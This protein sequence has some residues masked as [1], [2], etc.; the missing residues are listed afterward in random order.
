MLLYLL[1]FLGGVLT[2]MSPCVLPVLPF[3]F[4]RSDQP[5]RRGGLPL[6][7]GMAA[8]FAAVAAAATFAGAWIVRANQIGRFV[9]MFIF[10]LMGIAL[11]FPRV[12][13]YLSR[14]FVQLGGRVRH[15][16]KGEPSVAQSLLLGI[17]TGLLWAPCAG[18]ILGLILTGAAVSG[19]SVHT[20]FLLLGFAAG[21]G[22]S[23]SVALFAGGGVF[24]LMKRSLGAE[25]WI[26]RALGVAVLAGVVAIAFGWDQGILQRIFLAST[27]GIEQ[28]L[29][30]HLRPSSPPEDTS[31]AAPQPSAVMTSSQPAGPAMMSL[32]KSN[33]GPAMMSS[34]NTG[35]AMMSSSN[36]GQSS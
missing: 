24:S 9:A 23:L 14:P 30:E 29:V 18:P 4:S 36:A 33:A 3:V 22:A 17:S 26:R 2:I 13:E 12:A 1:A 7:A 21:A 10:A 11:L 6:L 34:S 32:S 19:P 25:E 5:F 16:G 8:T 20:F 31:S 27:S 15:E 35:P 28:T